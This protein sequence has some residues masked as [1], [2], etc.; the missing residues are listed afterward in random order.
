MA[1]AA[2][3]I[4]L[5]DE[6]GVGTLPSAPRGAIEG[7]RHARSWRLRLAAASRDG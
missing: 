2:R 1:A 3:L 4:A 5:I 6:R 7:P